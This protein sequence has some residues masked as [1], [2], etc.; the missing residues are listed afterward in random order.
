PAYYMLGLCYK[1]KHNDIKA[2]EALKKHIE[3]TQHAA[4]NGHVDL[5]EVYMRNDRDAEAEEQ[6]DLALADALGPC[7]RAHNALGKLLEKRGDY[8]AANYHFMTALGDPPWF[9][10][11][12]WM[13]LVENLMKT[14]DWTEAIGQIR[15]MLGRGKSG[16]LRH[17]DFARM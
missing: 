12:C 5:G 14:Q 13:N 17:I 9:Y 6:F 4:P 2:I 1:I 7:P 10:T 3:Q 11:E 16:S 8:P 15:D